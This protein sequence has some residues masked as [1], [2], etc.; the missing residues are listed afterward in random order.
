MT[1]SVQ[2]IA[3]VAV[4]ALVTACGANSH[5]N[6]KATPVPSTSAERRVARAPAKSARP[7]TAPALSKQLSASVN[8]PADAELALRAKALEVFAL[9]DHLIAAGP[10]GAADLVGAVAS[11]M[12]AG[13]LSDR[14]YEEIAGV[15]DSFGPDGLT[16][17]SSPLAIAVDLD[18]A[19]VSV[20]F[21]AVMRFDGGEALA[22]WR[23]TTMRFESEPSGWALV[24]W[25]TRPGP[26]PGPM[27]ELTVTA[28]QLDRELAGFAPI[29]VS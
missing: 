15:I 13:A 20:W 10:H 29:A 26:T 16:L 3:C 11:P 8:P 6:E 21:V 4:L 22:T 17:T 19:T 28:S 5:G 7:T 27:D 12:S 24:D 9:A 23:T 14:V 25:S 2:R 18:A 1:R